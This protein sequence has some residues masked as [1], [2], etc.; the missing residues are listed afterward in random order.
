MK[1]FF[2]ITESIIYICF[3]LCD[4]LLINSTYIKYLGVLLC[5]VFAIYNKDKYKSISLLFTLFADYFLLVL[6]NHYEIGVLSFIL[7]Q[8]VY[9][10]LISSSND[11]RINSI[12][13]RIGVIVIGLFLLWYFDNYTILNVLTIIYFSNLLVNTI[14]SYRCN[15]VLLSVGLSLF[16]CCDICVGMHNILQTNTFFSFLMWFFYLPSQV[17]IVL[18]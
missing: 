15:N 5:F 7:V 12:Y 3:L 10:F 16:L 14:L 1:K 9:A 11:Q 17:L 18:S 13:I 2:I 6:D 8:L 4:L